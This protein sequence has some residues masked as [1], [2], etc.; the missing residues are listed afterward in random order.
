MSAPAYFQLLNT[1]LDS[2]AAYAADPILIKRLRRIREEPSPAPRPHAHGEVADGQVP[3]RRIRRPAAHRTQKGRLTPRRADL[4]GRGDRTHCRARHRR[5]ARRIRK[6]STSSASPPRTP[7]RTSPRPRQPPKGPSRPKRRPPIRPSTSSTRPPRS[8]SST[9]SGVTVG[10]AAKFR[11]HL[12]SN[13]WNVTDGNHSTN[14]SSSV[15]YYSDD[16]YE[17]QAGAL[18]AEP[19]SRLSEVRGVP[20]P[21]HPAHHLRHRREGPRQPR[22]RRRLRPTVPCHRGHRQLSTAVPH[23]LGN[24]P[25]RACKL[26]G[27]ASR[28]GWRQC[29]RYKETCRNRQSSGHTV[30]RVDRGAAFNRAAATGTNN[31]VP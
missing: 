5:T 24:A 10:A 18:A 12:E 7:R 3:T 14:E 20:R 13:G 15:V 2:P 31:G 9:A 23:P 28:I 16:E 11:E 6:P 19:V 26:A 22:R 17:M 1:L 21:G 8:T 4:A 27:S 29:M 30:T 25:F